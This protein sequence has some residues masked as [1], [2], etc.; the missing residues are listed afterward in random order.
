MELASNYNHGPI[1]MKTI[2]EN[3]GISKNYLENIFIPLRLGGLIKTVRGPGGGYILARP[4]GEIHLN[5]IYNCLEGTTDIVDCTLAGKNCDKAATCRTKILWD[6][7]GKTIEN[8][9]ARYT[10]EDLIGCS[11]P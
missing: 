2:S 3:Q 9:L 6:E 4:P 8:T 5:E 7:I 1:L 11:F 10:L